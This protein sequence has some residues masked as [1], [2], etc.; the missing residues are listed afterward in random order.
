MQSHGYY[1]NFWLKAVCILN[2]KSIQEL[3]VL[4]KVDFYHKKQR[5]VHLLDLL[6]L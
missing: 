5:S 1:D 6:N 2:L 3:Y 4:L